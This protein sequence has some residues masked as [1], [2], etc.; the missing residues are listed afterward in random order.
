MHTELKVNIYLRTAKLTIAFKPFSF[1]CLVRMVC[2]WGKGARVGVSLLLEYVV[3]ATM[4][5]RCFIFTP[6]T[7]QRALSLLPNIRLRSS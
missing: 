3:Y 6:T 5:V 7:Q 2:G 4:I 1:N